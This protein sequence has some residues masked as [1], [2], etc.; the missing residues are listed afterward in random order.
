MNKNFLLSLFLVII[1]VAC[2][3]DTDQ[4]INSETNDENSTEAETT[5]S[6]TSDEEGEE[7]TED[8]DKSEPEETTDSNTS[9]SDEQNNHNAPLS[10]LQVHYINVGQADATLFEYADQDDS[11]TILFDTGDWRSN[12]VVNY[13]ASQDVSYLDLIV[14]SHPDADHIGQ[15]AEVVN[16]YGAGEVWMSGNESSSQTFQ[17]AVEAVISSEADFHEPRTGEQFEIGPMEI[18]VLYPKTI[19]GKT[20]EESVSLKF[21]YGEVEFLFTGDADQN[22]ESNMLSSGLD[23]DVDIL[24]LGHHG[25]NTSS[26]PAFIDATNPSVAIYSA[27]VDS[28]YG[29]PHE[30]VVSLIQNA[31]IDL[32]GTDA[33]GT[34]VIT[35]DGNNYDIMTNKDGTISPESTGQADNSGSGDDEET[36]ENKTAE[37][38]DSSNCVDINTATLEEIQEIIHFGPSRAQDLI[39]QRPYNSVDDLRN[40]SGI[41]P[42][43]LADIKEEGIACTGG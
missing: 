40:I 37:E 34:I 39:D 26:S 31:G 13:L 33:H 18:D 35:T 3:Q 29:H 41:G 27:G 4:N 10:G 42:S 32:Y 12:D 28:Q 8:E 23:L 38:D 1:L 6:H 20:N 21:T 7:S 36:Q 22:A 15:L 14:V 17:R 9:N 16:T 19:S 5:E 24:Q 2:G 25:S 11:Y 30:E 43:R